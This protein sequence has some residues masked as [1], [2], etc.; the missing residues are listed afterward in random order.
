[1]VQY[2]N[3]ED[4]CL[5]ITVLGNNQKIE[6]MTLYIYLPCTQ[7]DVGYRAKFAAYVQSE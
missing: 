7:N 1:M 6:N 4:A 2:P 3:C 5:A